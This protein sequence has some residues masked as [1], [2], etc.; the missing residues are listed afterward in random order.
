M[1][2]HS[3]KKPLVVGL[4]AAHPFVLESLA[5]AIRAPEFRLVAKRLDAPDTAAIEWP[6]A[7]VY[8]FDAHGPRPIVESHLA[9]L[10]AARS[11][12]GAPPPTLV[13]AERFNEPASFAFLRLG[14]RGLLTYAEA[15]QRLPDALRLVAAG[16]YWVPR[17]LLGRFVESILGAS[18][19]PVAAR[20]SAASARLSQR[21][22]QVLDALLE[23]LAN[24]EIAARLNISERTV[25]FH[26]S[27]L[28]RKFAVR[29]RADLIL[30][31]YQSQS[32]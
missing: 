24:K 31:T 15:K 17:A 11:Q 26:V 32:R 23:N 21:E 27:N 25:K 9:G 2:R 1:G 22:K 6:A 14:V 7:H 18:S 13:L 20:A 28:L 29:R 3:R 19:R 16:G 5:G 30:L 12:H 10:L 8:V 4:M